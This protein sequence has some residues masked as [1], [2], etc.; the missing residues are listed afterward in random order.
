MLAPRSAPGEP[1]T[2]DLPPAASS[3]PA[4][5]AP[6]AATP[7]A[8]RRTPARS[9][10]PPSARRRCAG[11]RAAPPRSAASVATVYAGLPS[12]RAHPPRPQLV[13]LALVHRLE[14]PC[15]RAAGARVSAPCARVPPRPPPRARRTLAGAASSACSNATSGSH[16]SQQRP[17]GAPRARVAEVVEDLAPAAR[18]PVRAV[19][20]DRAV[21]LPAAV[22]RRLDRRVRLARAAAARQRHQQPVAARPARAPPHRLARRSTA[23]PARARPARRARSPARRRP[24]PRAGRA[25]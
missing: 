21:G 15:R 14:R 16:T 3:P 24:R 2:T 6:P 9:R 10:G 20:L 11:A 1:P 13:E 5:P 12:A 4:P 17:V 18:L 7:R 22:P 8:S 25:T 23:A 19:A